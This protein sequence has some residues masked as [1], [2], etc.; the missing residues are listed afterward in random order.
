MRVSTQ[1]SDM[2]EG[3]GPKTGRKFGHHL[4]MVPNLFYITLNLVVG[5]FV[6]RASGLE[7]KT[8]SANC[9]RKK[10]SR[11]NCRAE[12]E[13]LFLRSVSNRELLFIHSTAM[14]FGRKF[15]H[16]I[17][18]VPNLFY[19]TLNLVVGS[20]VWRASGLEEKTL[21]ANC[22]RKKKSRRNCRA[23]SEWLFLRSVS[24]RELLFINSTATPIG[25][26]NAELPTMLKKYW[27]V[28]KVHPCAWNFMKSR[29]FLSVYNCTTLF[30]LN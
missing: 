14:P 13:W 12:S 30:C 20:F 28:C 7:E 8:L 17:W 10:K 26:P 24:N 15:G 25:R 11:R 22:V 4:W 23:E 1:N 21:S 29:K 6:W 2:G 16:H 5:S 27:P 3:G 9:V 19:I 18:M